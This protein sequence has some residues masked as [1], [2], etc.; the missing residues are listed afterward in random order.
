MVDTPPQGQAALRLLSRAARALVEEG[1]V[2]TEGLLAAYR[3]LRPL[4]FAGEHDDAGADRLDVGFLLRCRSLGGDALLRARRIVV[5]R[6]L[7]RTGVTI[8]RMDE[9]PSAVR[10]RGPADDDASGEALALALGLSLEA[11]KLAHGLGAPA[12]VLRAA[13]ATPLDARAAVDAL[14]EGGA[15]RE[16]ELVREDAARV[17]GAALAALVQDRPVYVV[18][19]AGAHRVHDLVSPYTRRLR[20][21]LV[22]LGKDLG[23]PRDDEPYAALDVLLR[24][25]HVHAERRAV[26][27]ADGFVS[28]GPGVVVVRCEAFPDAEADRRC[29]EALVQLKRARALLV[30]VEASGAS[31]EQALQ[32]LGGSTRAVALLVE[33]TSECAPE[34][35][36]EP[37]ADHVA[38]VSNALEG[39]GTSVT[40]PS[41]AF[42]GEGDGRAADAQAFPLVQAVLRARAHEVIPDTTRVALKIS[43]VGDV[44]GMSRACIDV[45]GRLGPAQV[46]T[47]RR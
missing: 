8:T 22:K 38:V 14:A 15:A 46:S 5:E 25:E 11:A 27:A 39:G 36:V 16:I 4:G 7:P 23:A 29:R 3:A 30:L 43:R 19:G 31:L 33:G 34:L 47:R 24:D 13:F 20:E 45:L 9:E 40:L 41:L 10:W 12:D 44:S 37:A 18:A 21:D 35:V 17:D 6:A 26:E 1:R 42:L 2:S 28:A 32:I